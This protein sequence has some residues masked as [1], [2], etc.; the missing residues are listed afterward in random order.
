MTRES[1]RTAPANPML[2]A[3]PA[4]TRIR[5]AGLLGGGLIVLVLART[6]VILHVPIRCRFHDVTG[7]PCPTCGM[8]HA[9]TALIQGQWG[10]AA[11][12]HAGVFV[13]AA[14]GILM[15]VTLACELATGRDFLG[16]MPVR[17][18]LIL[19]F[20]AVA[21]AAGGWALNLSRLDG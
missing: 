1:H 20:V 21:A 11:G 12:H 7:I 13:L 18:W 4:G 10:N 8:T 19:I 9:V 14:L 2:R 3:S 17:F 15:A 6:G 16:R 5:A